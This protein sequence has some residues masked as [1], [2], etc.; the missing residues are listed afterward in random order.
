MEMRNVTFESNYAGQGGV[1]VGIQEGVIEV[2]NC[3]FRKN[4]GI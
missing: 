2:D 3:T 1:F 4:F